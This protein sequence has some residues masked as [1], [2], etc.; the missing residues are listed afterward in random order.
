MKNLTEIFTEEENEE[1]ED[2][3]VKTRADFNALT[4]VDRLAFINAGGTI[5]E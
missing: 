3:K 4:P 2:G 1:G 5:V